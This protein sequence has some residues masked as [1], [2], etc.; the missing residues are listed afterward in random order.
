MSISTSGRRRPSCHR[1]RAHHREWVDRPGRRPGPLPHSRAPVARRSQA[2]EAEGSLRHRLATMQARAT[3]GARAPA[4]ARTTTSGSSTSS[5]AWKSPRREA[6]R[7]ASTT[8]R[9]RSTSRSGS[10]EPP[11]I[12]RRARLASWRGGRACASTIERGLVRMAPRQTIVQ[13]E[14]HPLKPRRVS[15]SE[16]RSSIAIPTRIAQE[17]LHAGRNEEVAIGRVGH[18]LIIGSGRVGLER[19]LTAG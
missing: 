14:R 16:G 8:A 4:S 1:A 5:S 18:R 17:G 19:V 6:A 10:V 9:C 3:F 7:K 2:A 11:R 12:R 13:H 15:W